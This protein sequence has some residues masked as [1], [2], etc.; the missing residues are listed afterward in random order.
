[1]LTYGRH[2]SGED[3]IVQSAPTTGEMRRARG[4]KK[5]SLGMLP[6]LEAF[7]PAL[8][9]YIQNPVPLGQRSTTVQPP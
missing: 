8:Q 4:G 2:L 5:P 3:D 6:F 7:E 1:V 9:T